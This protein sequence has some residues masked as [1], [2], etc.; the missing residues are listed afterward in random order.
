MVALLSGAWAADMPVK[1]PILIAPYDWTGFY[2]GV[3]AGY[4]VARNSSRYTNVELPFPGLSNDETYKISPHGFV[5]GA[6]LGYNWQFSGWLAGLEADFQGTSQQDT[7]CVFQCTLN[8]LVSGT[9]V[10]KLRWFGT[11]RGRLVA[12][13]DRLLL[14]VT[15]VA[16]DRQ[17]TIDS[18]TRQ[19]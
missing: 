7:T 3:N 9:T 2:A 6:Q 15:G 14:Y 18:R 16:V 11:V 5:G 17:F 12:G 8:G 10:Q 19:L 4:S 1:A 13:L